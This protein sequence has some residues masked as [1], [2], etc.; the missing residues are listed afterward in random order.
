MA[1][2]AE[3]LT[4]F[5]RMISGYLEESILGKAIKA[6]V[7]SVSVLDIRA[8]AEGKHRTADDVPYGGGGGMVMRVGPVVAAI[9]DA[10]RRL[11]SGRVLLMSP[12]GAALTQ[13]RLREFGAY[14]GGLILVCGRYEGVDERVVGFVDEEVSIGDFVITGGELAAL[15]LID[16]AARLQPGVL[17]NEASPL[18]ESF[19]GGLL[20]HPQYTRPPEFRGRRVP[21]I[22]LS[23]DHARVARWRRWHQLTQTRA[24]RPELFRAL[25]LDAED[26]ALLELTEDQL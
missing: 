24:R 14:P 25:A 4:L 19:E 12:R 7:L 15:V 3:V 21:E 26:R 11:P 10:K 6:G 9:E 23:G 13:A 16:G 20:E 17:G 8:H 18:S 22:L 2:R 1:F 5:P